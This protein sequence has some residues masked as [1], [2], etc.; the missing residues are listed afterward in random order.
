MSTNP[1]TDTT[2]YIRRWKLTVQTW[3]G[4]DIEIDQE[5]RF[6]F[7]VNKSITRIYQFSEI[8][9]YNLSPDTETSIFKNAKSVTLEA[10]YQ[11]G[12]YGQIFNGSV[13]QVIRGKENGVTYFCKLI[14]IDGDD[15]LNIGF[16]NLVL[17]E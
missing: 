2:Q 9:I 15:L 5:L 7:T 12:A 14:C 11:N 1:P 3:G 8:V 13:R 6:T 4:L 17:T 16:A 10:G